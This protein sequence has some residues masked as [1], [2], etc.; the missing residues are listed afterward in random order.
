MSKAVFETLPEFYASDVALF[1][2]LYLKRFLEYGMETIPLTVKMPRIRFLFSPEGWV[3]AARFFARGE[4][5]GETPGELC[6]AA[7]EKRTLAACESYERC[8]REHVLTHEQKVDFY[9]LL[10]LKPFELAYR[11]MNATIHTDR[12][13]YREL[14]FK[15]VAFFLGLLHFLTQKDCVC[16]LGMFFVRDMLTEFANPVNWMC[17]KL[18]PYP[19]A[20]FDMFG[21]PI[22][23]GLYCVPLVE[24][25]CKSLS[26][27]LVKFYEYVVLHILDDDLP[28]CEACKLFRGFRGDGPSR[29]KECEQLCFLKEKLLKINT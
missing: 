9:H 17:G 13:R 19:R 23:D 8:V 11:E 5:E 1:S 22:L 26:A 16:A 7:I 12:P 2:K 28:P 6:F 20:E 14:Y 10:M 29:P 21:L 4:L 27:F 25:Q 18:D 3:T 24:S 15:Y